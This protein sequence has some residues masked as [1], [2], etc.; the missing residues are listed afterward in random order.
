VD[1]AILLEAARQVATCPFQDCA[2]LIDAVS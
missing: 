1:Q 2:Q